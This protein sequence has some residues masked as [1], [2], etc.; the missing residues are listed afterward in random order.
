MLHP[1]PGQSLIYLVLYVN[2]FT[3]FSPSD[4]IK[5]WFKS[6]LQSKL[7]VNFMLTVK[8]FLSCYYDW[9]SRPSGAVL[10]HLL[11]EESV[12]DLSDLES[13]SDTDDESKF[14]RKGRRSKRSRANDDGDFAYNEEMSSE[15]Y[16]RTDCFKVEKHLLVYG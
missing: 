9:H 8:W 4:N 15:G 3:Y 1:L 6:M 10:V 12:V 13:S 14:G 11:Q 5:Q 2:N 16:T 7:W